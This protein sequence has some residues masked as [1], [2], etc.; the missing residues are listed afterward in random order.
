MSTPERFHG[1]TPPFREPT[2]SEL[3]DFIRE[4]LLPRLT[5]LELEVIK[6][7][8]VTWP[9]C[10]GLLEA[11]QLDK[12]SEKRKFLEGLDEDEVKLLL[13]LKSNGSLL[14]HEYLEVKK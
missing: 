1:E 2:V 7:R 11:N 13:K 4:I 9:V 3:S 6:L 14:H 8:R 10:Q 12:I 5:E